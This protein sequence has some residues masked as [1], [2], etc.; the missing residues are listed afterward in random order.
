MSFLDEC[1]KE[2]RALKD[3]ERDRMKN[4]LSLLHNYCGGENEITSEKQRKALKDVE[5]ASTKDASSLIHYYR[6]NKMDSQS[7]QQAIEERIQ[8]GA[9]RNAGQCAA[10]SQPQPPSSSSS[11]HNE[12]QQDNHPEVFGSSTEVPMGSDD[13]SNSLSHCSNSG[14]TPHR[15]CS[16]LSASISEFLSLSFASS[17]SSQHFEDNK[18]GRH[19]AGDNADVFNHDD[20]TTRIG[21]VD[22]EKRI[23]DGSRLIDKVEITDRAVSENYHDDQDNGENDDEDYV[24][25]G[26]LSVSHMQSDHS[27]YH[28][29]SEMIQ[30]NIDSGELS[31]EASARHS[32]PMGC[33]FDSTNSS[34]DD[35][36]KNASNGNS[37]ETNTNIGPYSDCGGH[38]KI[39]D[40]ARG[41]L[42]SIQ[43][44]SDSWSRK[45]SEAEKINSLDIVQQQ[46]VVPTL[47][48]IMFNSPVLGPL[49]KI[50]IEDEGFCDA[51]EEIS[52]QSLSRDDEGISCDGRFSDPNY[53]Y[54]KTMAGQKTRL[55]FDRAESKWKKVVRFAENHNDDLEW[56]DPADHHIMKSHNNFFDDSNILDIY[57]EAWDCPFHDNINPLRKFSKAEIHRAL[58]TDDWEE[59]SDCENSES[60]CDSDEEQDKAI[61]RGLLFSVA[62]NGLSV[63]AA[64]LASIMRKGNDELIGE[65][66][67]MFGAE[68]TEDNIKTTASASAYNYGGSGASVVNPTGSTG[69]SL[70][71]TTTAT[72]SAY[73]GA[74]SASISS[75][76]SS[77]AS[78]S[79]ASA[80]TASASAATSVTSSTTTSATLAAATSSATATTTSSASLSAVASSASASAVSTTA[81]STSVAVAT[82]ASNLAVATST[83][84]LAVATSATNL[85]AAS[86]TGAAAAGQTAAAVATATQ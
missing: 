7:Q 32:I 37:T 17:L 57:H 12:S 9:R 8:N 53:I 82:S 29:S 30:K 62:G 85:I 2:Q 20:E 13:I 55:E 81:S 67:A 51:M 54:K 41:G 84:N 66:E 74:A 83:S 40:G 14:E 86:S 26:E 10:S 46:Q 27:N 59:M 75:T 22:I 65:D 21:I 77:S 34:I 11:S 70:N 49:P 1:Q 33:S 45:K 47:R 38:E 73:D 78:A 31:D 50:S 43:P 69:S 3:K 15:D 52:D 48:G 24:E 18:P 80:S 79:T 71:T 4:A 23:A 5:G 61:I 39:K 63:V 68:L 36:S 60:S 35:K 16:E 6:E 58:Y 64:K 56:F 19:L 25:D 76:C 72:V 28:S 44:S 42:S